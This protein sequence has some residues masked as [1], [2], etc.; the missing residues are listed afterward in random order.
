MKFAAVWLLLGLN[1]GVDVSPMPIDEVYAQAALQSL[2][3]PVL[4]PEAPDFGLIDVRLNRLPHA[5]LGS[6]QSYTL[7]FVKGQQSF[8]LQSRLSG[9]Q[10]PASA[11]DKLVMG[12]SEPVLLQGYAFE[13]QVLEVLSPACS[14]TGHALTTDAITPD[15]GRELLQSLRWYLPLNYRQPYPFTLPP[16]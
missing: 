8:M 12:Q 1:S 2:P 3:F 4:V 6:E 11:C 15:Q 5:R 14:P 13:P 10:H 16:P 7:V 9:Y